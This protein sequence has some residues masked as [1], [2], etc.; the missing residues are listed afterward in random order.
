M[1]VLSPDFRHDLFVSYSH[2]DV[3]GTGNSQLKAWSKQFVLDLAE[4]L[5]L[6]EP[7]FA[8]LEIF[9]DER[10]ERGL[11]ST[12][13]LSDQIQAEISSAAIL[14]LLLS[15][16]YV[17]SRWCRDEL[18][19]WLNEHLVRSDGRI[20]PIRVMPVDDHEWPAA[21]KDSRGEPLIGFFFH[22]KGKAV[23]AARPFRWRG[24]TSDADAYNTEML[25]LVMHLIARVKEIH[26]DVARARN[27]VLQTQRLAAATGQV[28]Y[29]YARDA[30]RAEWDALRTLLEAQ[31]YMVQPNEPDR[32]PDEAGAERRRREERVRTLSACD[33]LLIVAGADRAGLDA[34]L[35]VIGRRDRHLA[36]ALAE[37]PLPCAVL[38][39]GTTQQADARFSAMAARLGIQWIDSTRSDWLTPLRDWLLSV[40]KTMEA[41]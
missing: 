11:D 24:A 21:L 33:A 10:P 39:G 3:D 40:A 16:Q 15:P 36:K 37:R 14:T 8:G 41:A 25:R 38:A 30:H 29:L 12:L 28:L 31:G 4:E 34:D 32:G 22:P 27:A 13:P 9:L 1:A 26:A 35:V 23:G 19:W 2:G 20:F 6:S 7:D 17:R 18:E 5:R